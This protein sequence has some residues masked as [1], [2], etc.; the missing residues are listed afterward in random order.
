[1]FLK[2]TFFIVF[3]SRIFSVYALNEK[4]LKSGFVEL[5]KIAPTILVNLK[6]AIRDN[7]TGAKLNGVNSNRAITTIEAALALKEVQKDAIAMGFSLVIYNAYIPKKAL[8]NLIEFI[9]RTEDTKYWPRINDKLI[10]KEEYVKSKIS[11]TRGSTVDVTLISLDD[12]I[13]SPPKNISKRH[14]SGIN[15]T[16]VNDGTLA[17]GS[18]YDLFDD[19]SSVNFEN[20]IKVKEIQNRQLLTKLMKDHGF[21]Q[22]KKM[23]WQ[24]TLIREPYMDSEWDFNF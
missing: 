5:N 18:F 21:Y 1:M 12:E 8:K 14:Y 2:V 16:Y 3:L 13:F 6:Y 15:L 20:K 23:W 19:T 4:E 17:M 22:D 11:H 24:F 10:V 9:D 7:I